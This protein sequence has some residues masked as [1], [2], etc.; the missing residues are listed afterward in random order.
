MSVA[1]SVVVA[2]FT[3]SLVFV[4]LAILYAMVMVLSAVLRTKVSRQAVVE[5]TKDLAETANK[6]LD[7]DVIRA[8]SGEIKLKNVDEKTA[9][10]I[11]AIVSDE[12]QISLSE[13]CFKSITAV[14]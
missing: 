14:E 11:M 2:M 10:M 7:M 9:A 3:L 5:N 8:S 1:E 4:V 6:D 13:L 12:S